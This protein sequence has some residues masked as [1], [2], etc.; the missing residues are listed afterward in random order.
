MPSLEQLA[1]LQATLT[2]QLPIGSPGPCSGRS[3]GERELP[4][5]RNSDKRS[6][7]VRVAEVRGDIPWGGSGAPQS[8]SGSHPG[9][10]AL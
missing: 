9:T 7:Y 10:F 2:S 5:T 6:G 3:P 8:V 4:S 1:I